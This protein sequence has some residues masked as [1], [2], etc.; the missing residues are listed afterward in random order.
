MRSHDIVSAAQV[1]A[2]SHVELYLLTK[3]E[4]KHVLHWGKQ[5]MLSDMLQHIAASN[6][7]DIFHQSQRRAHDEALTFATWLVCLFVCLFVCV[8]LV[9]VDCRSTLS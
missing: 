6:A 3:S 1:I 7:L 2:V 5:V 9:W 8:W 4:M